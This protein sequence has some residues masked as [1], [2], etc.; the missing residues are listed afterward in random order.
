MGPG[1]LT[2][3]NQPPIRRTRNDTRPRINTDF[4]ETSCRLARE[5]FEI[6]D[7]MLMVARYWPDDALL[8]KE[9]R[10]DQILVKMGL[11]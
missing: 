9:P 1:R 5:A 8:R 4:A 7:P 6:R 10:F 3:R 11:K 2:I